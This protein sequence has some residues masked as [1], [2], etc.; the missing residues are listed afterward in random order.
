MDK[1]DIIFKNFNPRTTLD[2][3]EALKLML[4]GYLITESTM[5]SKS[6]YKGEFYYYYLDHFYAIY[7]NE[8]QPIKRLIDVNALPGKYFSTC[9]ITESLIPKSLWRS[10]LKTGQIY[11]LNFKYIF[12]ENKVNEHKF[13]VI[14]SYEID[15]NEVGISLIF[16]ATVKT[17]SNF[18]RDFT[19]WYCSDINTKNVFFTKKEAENNLKFYIEELLSKK[20]LGK[21]EKAFVRKTLKESPELLL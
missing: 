16:D 6:S 17:S 18:I 19:P 14:V 8:N 5:I 11:E 20:R 2:K 21:N 3:A 12:S 7:Y 9:F 10:N 13:E 15:N 4:S 1:D